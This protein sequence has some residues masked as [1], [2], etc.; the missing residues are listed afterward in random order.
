MLMHFAVAT[1]LSTI[2]FTSISASYAHHK[3]QA[4]L[5]PN[6]R[7]LT[8]GIIIGTIIGAGAADYMSSDILSK[9]FGCFE[10]LVAYQISLAKTTPSKYIRPGNA[11]TLTAGTGIGGISAILGIGGGTLTIPFLIACRVNIHK[12]IGSATACSLAIAL[13]G[14]IMMILNGLSHDAL[15]QNTLG[16]V[17]WPATLAITATSIPFAR[18]GAKLAHNIPATIVKRMLAL[19]LAGI[20]LRMLF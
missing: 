16:Y 18:L 10:L 9:I 11:T 7:L 1:S 5:W 4:I 13:T 17:Y 8:P 2:V 20:G 14:T 3:A 6:V 15:P 12:A 19:I